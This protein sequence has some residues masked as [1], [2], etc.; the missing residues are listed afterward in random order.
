MGITAEHTDLVE[1]HRPA[2]TGA[3]NTETWAGGSSSSPGL[4]KPPLILNSFHSAVSRTFELFVK[5]STSSATHLQRGEAPG[6]TAAAPGLP[7]QT[8]TCLIRKRG[9]PAEDTPTPAQNTVRQ[10]QQGKALNTPQSHFC[11]H[12]P[13]QGEMKGTQ[14]NSNPPPIT[15]ER[16]N[17]CSGLCTSQKHTPK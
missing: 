16:Q 2:A 11:K 6:S 15:E 7:E 12:F 5:D 17:T 9:C 3:P 4:W 14:T 1:R 8:V 10:N 13:A